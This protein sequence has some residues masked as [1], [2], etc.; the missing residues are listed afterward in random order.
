MNEN[1]NKDIVSM[2]KE[3][4]LAM[5]SP[6]RVLLYCKDLMCEYNAT[7]RKIRPFNSVMWYNTKEY[8]IFFDY[9]DSEYL[10][11]EY[12]NFIALNLSDISAN[13]KLGDRELFESFV[14]FLTFLDGIYDL[15]GIILDFLVD[16]KLYNGHM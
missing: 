7:T 13:I 16:R 8:D 1:T 12:N 4:L 9:F 10:E 6:V 14:G 11:N 3:Q 15:N 5:R 2:Y